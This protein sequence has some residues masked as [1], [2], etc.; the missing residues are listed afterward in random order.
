MAAFGRRRPNVGRLARRGDIEGLRKA[1]RLREMSVDEQG[2][3]WD[4]TVDIRASAASAL[5]KFEA[6]GIAEDL[7]TALA[8]P[9][10]AVRGAAIATASRLGTTAG[11]EPL[12]DCVAERP[13]GDEELSAKALDL[14]V[15]WRLE[16]AAEGLADRLLR[17][18]RATVEDD[19]LDALDRLLGADPRGDAARDAVIHTVVA[20]IGA[21]RNGDR[22]AKATRILLRLGRGAVDHVHASLSDGK[23]TP[24]M[25]TAAG[26][27]GDARAVG[28]LIGAMNSPDPDVRASA[29]TAAGKLNHTQAVPALLSATQD[30]EQAVR[31]AASAALDR[32]GTAA[33]IAGLAA[34]TNTDAS[35]VFPS[36]P[37]IAPSEQPELAHSSEPAAEEAP[38]DSEAT[39]E[40]EAPPEPEATSEPEAPYEPE[41]DAPPEPE[42]SPEA[43]APLAPE[44]FP[45]PEAPEP[46]EIAS[47]FPQTR[48]ALGTARTSASPVDGDAPNQGSRRRSGGL[49][50]RL[51]RWNR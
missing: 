8:D 51:R 44:A 24:G 5:E 49:V 7:A 29:A 41:V 39:S 48:Q 37:V 18:D 35:S 16:G 6:E 32:M 42:A 2:V 19:E 38:P 1:L 50:G 34:L 46:R 22:E 15:S 23:A 26:L 40:R 3:E 31:D 9:H 12:L 14:L 43:E 20:R 11:V 17:A 33:V 21:G 25:V 10:P 45:E 30:R 36:D 13:A 47:V 28:S 27:L 4:L